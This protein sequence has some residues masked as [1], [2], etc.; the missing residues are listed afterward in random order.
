MTAPEGVEIA[1]T[2]RPAGAVAH[3]S[4]DAGG[5]RARTRA[6]WLAL[7]PARR[8][9]LRDSWRA[10][11]TSRLLVWT[12]GV[13]TLAGFG[14]GPIRNAFDPPHTTRGFGWLGDLLAAPAARW[15]SDWYLVI[16]RFGYHPELGSLTAG[17][18]AYFPLYPLGMRA[19]SW[20]GPPLIVAGVLL[21]VVA[22]MGAL[23]GVHRLTTLELARVRRPA[24]A[25]RGAEDAARLAVLSLAFAPMA[26]F[27]SAVYNESLYMA[28]GVA[29][30][31]SARHGRWWLVGVLGA[32]A[33]A[34]RSTGLVFVLPA[35]V[36]YLYGPREDRV[37][38]FAPA[39]AG[40]RASAALRAL[41]PR[42]RL[43]R[44]V[45]WL[46]V[47]PLGAA[48]YALWLGLESGDAIA[49]FHAQQGWGRHLVAPY[50]GAWDGLVAAFDGA[51]QLLS[52]QRAHVYFRLAGGDPFIAAEHNLML[53]AFLLATIP[54]LVGVFRLLAP[55]YGVYVLAALAVPLSY[56]V[57]PQPLMSVPRYAVVLFPLNMWLGAW[58]A[59][60][61]RA[62]RPVLVGS[63]LLM[64]FFVAEF[65]TWHWV[66]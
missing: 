14:F 41:R 50:R 35:L 39:A 34:T 15:D 55:A 27:F 31:W 36:L 65:A 33:G 1:I 24:L 44:D 37:P 59:E 58:L 64:A 7:D 16:A 54:L 26:F 28:I 8:L 32:L 22:F 48:L 12:V 60:H 51:R 38:D 19:I 17:R 63:A 25:G 46:A 9:A 62:R 61:P 57:A 49:P 2:D 40:P 29:L 52:G 53:I 3:R 5:L 6:A 47:M 10:L 4:A 45:L 23:Y 42:Y 43:R 30:F 13:A 18:T 56:P 21:S 11:W 66:A 20:L